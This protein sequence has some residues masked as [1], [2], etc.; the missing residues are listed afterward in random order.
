MLRVHLSSLLD[1][2]LTSTPRVARRVGWKGAAG[3]ASK[4]LQPG[5]TTVVG[6]VCEDPGK[7]RRKFE[8]FGRSASCCCSLVWVTCV[9]WCASV[10]ARVCVDAREKRTGFFHCFN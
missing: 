3:L 6:C 10:G 2:R 5:W 4:L 9:S 8:S 1:F 7:S